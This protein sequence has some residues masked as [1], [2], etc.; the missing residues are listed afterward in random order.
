LY[1]VY[2]HGNWLFTTWRKVKVGDIV[3]VLDKEFFPADLVLLSSGFVEMNFLSK[4]KILSISSEPHSICY[5]QTSNLDGETNL[6]VRQVRFYF[7]FRK[8]K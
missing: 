5:I 7:L 3:K 8:T 1:L 2:R 6:K 4:K